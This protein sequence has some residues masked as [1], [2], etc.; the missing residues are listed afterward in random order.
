MS[1]PTATPEDARRRAASHTRTTRTVRTVGIA[2]LAVL[3]A[4]LFP[5]PAMGQ[6]EPAELD[7]VALSTEESL[8]TVTVVA[9]PDLRS[10][11]VAADSFVVRMGDAEISPA[12]ERVPG[13]DL[14][15]VLL[16]D[17]SGSMTLEAMAAAKASGAAF[18]G[19]LP[20]RS[21]ISLVSFGDE[22]NVVQAFTSNHGE[23]VTAL[24]GLE[25]NGETAL[26][27]AVVTAAQQFDPRSDSV[28]TIV[29]LSD[30]G[31][32]VEQSSLGNAQA[33][34][35]ASGATLHAI[36]IETEETNGAE[37]E[38]LAEA[39][40]GTVGRVEQLESLEV[41]QRAIAVDLNNQYRL[42]FTA[43]GEG[44]QTA[45]LQALVSGRVIA[46]TTLTVQLP[47]A[48]EVV[49]EATTVP[50][51]PETAPI[52]PPPVEQRSASAP[53]I[54]QDE[55]SDMLLLKWLSIGAV[56]IA[57]AGIGLVLLTPKQRTAKR[58]KPAARFDAKPRRTGATKGLRWLTDRLADIVEGRLNRR[59]LGLRV[60]RLLDAA[61][62]KIRTSEFVVLVLAGAGAGF[63]V[64]ALRTLRFGLV[65]AG[66]VVLFMT[67]VVLLRV[68][69]RRSAFAEQ[70]V[71]A[72]QMLAGALRTGYSLPQA[73]ALLANEGDAPMSE[74]FARVSVEMRLGRDLVEALEAVSTR[75]K[76]DDFLW[77]VGA[78]D[79]AREVG[80]DLA[81][82]LDNVGE[83][84]R[85][86]ER[87]RRQIYSLSAEGRI[88]AYILILLPFPMF[89]WQLLVNREYT[90]LL[91][92]D[93]LGR[94]FFMGG[95]TMLVIGGFWLR[96]LIRVDY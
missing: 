94:A 80:G 72:L 54:S 61:G 59:P 96:R 5:V 40:N 69:R 45:L 24:N 12:I 36:S 3:V 57:M 82:V 63:L 10:A 9:P 93:P 74:E 95:I 2:I 23:V 75:M 92:N 8:V 51:V 22:A 55:V 18:I 91:I 28:R 42:R 4:L 34:L 78:I 44:S 31:N 7:V 58:F 41:L 83:T 70:L 38:A 68:K 37:L 50:V 67:V 19:Q 53:A 85:T 6:A 66:M 89:F 26:H 1:R 88:S 29:L 86:R 17:V 48:P 84:M 90:G 77:T 15:V 20:E 87:I 30:G 46:Q 33:A 65:L 13:E 39:S 73:I 47:V 16:V 79:I 56:A 14:D 52:A 35:R 76:N 11:D 49:A 71:A 21:R 60:T 43:P 27:A 81:G 62:W 32:T 64:G 25:A